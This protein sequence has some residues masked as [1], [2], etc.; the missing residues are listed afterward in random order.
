[1]KTILCLTLMCAASA[2]AQYSSKWSEFDSGRAAHNGG[3]ISHAGVF[4]GWLR[5]PMNSANYEIQQGYPTLPLPVQT[6]G[7]P[8]L[9]ITLVGNNARV[10]WPA[11]AT[12]FTL[13]ETAVIGSGVSWMSVPGPYQVN[14]NERFILVP[15]SQ[16]G[17]CYRLIAPI[18]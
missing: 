14:G 6:L 11:S 10:A 16:P 9:T 7:L 13:E 12:S 1:M 18:P 4:S 8:M 5:K 17:R 3:S 15:A 2:H